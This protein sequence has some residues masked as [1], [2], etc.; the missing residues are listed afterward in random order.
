MNFLKKYS[1]VAFVLP[2]FWN[3][4]FFWGIAAEVW[5]LIVFGGLIVT[6]CVSSRA[7]V[8]RIVVENSLIVIV[9][10]FGVYVGSLTF[11]TFGPGILVL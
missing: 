10:C 8:C 6:W 9:V 1:F 2:N 4:F 3:L 7:L 5:T 11:G